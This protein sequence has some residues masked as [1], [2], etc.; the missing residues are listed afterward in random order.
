[1]AILLEA[2]AFVNVQQSNGET[3]LMKVNASLGAVLPSDATWSCWGLQLLLCWGCCMMGTRLSVDLQVA[4][5]WENQTRKEAVTRC[6]ERRG[7]KSPG[8]YELMYSG[9][10]AQ[11]CGFE[12][13]LGMDLAGG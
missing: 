8:S 6:D 7:G 2:G 9:R 11:S 5:E 1:M 12:L 10:Q 3:A 13:S 4:A